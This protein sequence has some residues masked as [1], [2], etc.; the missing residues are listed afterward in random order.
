MVYVGGNEN[1][2][3]V[4]LRAEPAYSPGGGVAGHRMTSSDGTEYYLNGTQLIVTP[5]S[6]EGFHQAVLTWSMYGC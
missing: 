6:G 5:P 4:D 2:G 1:L 3:Y